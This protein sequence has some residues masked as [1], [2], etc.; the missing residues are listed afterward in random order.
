MN[1]S[2]WISSCELEHS[3]FGNGRG[4]MFFVQI[5]K[6][7]SAAKIINARIY[8]LWSLKSGGVGVCGNKSSNSI[9]GVKIKD[10]SAFTTVNS[11]V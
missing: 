11:V 1:S 3:F 9:Q 8:R 5:Y 6:L 4:V 10:F 7:W 2:S